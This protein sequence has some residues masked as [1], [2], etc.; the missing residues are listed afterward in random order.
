MSER[1]K[2]IM[3]GLEKGGV[4]V[5]EAMRHLRRMPY[6]D[7]GFAK[8]DSHRSLRRGFPE[9]VFGEGKSPE[10]ILKIAERIIS[11]DGVLLITRAGDK[12]F[13]K[14]K[15]AYPKAKFEKAARVI[16]YRSHPAVIKNGT[17]LVISAGTADI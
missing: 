8:V 12:V 4:S 16:Y 13:A 7:L 11:H 5:E 14:L 17:V 10:Q 2:N 15:R 6:E 9:V 1:I 3:E